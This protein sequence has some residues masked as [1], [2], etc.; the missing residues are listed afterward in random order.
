MSKIQ[1]YIRLNLFSQNICIDKHF[2]EQGGMSLKKK[3]DY[4]IRV[5][6]AE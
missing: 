1:F 4:H 3:E 5:E 6:G 2:L